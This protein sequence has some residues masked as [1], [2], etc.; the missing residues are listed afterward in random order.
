MRTQ[1]IQVL[2]QLGS[3]T[4]WV[5]CLCPS[6]DLAQKCTTDLA[7]VLPP[8]AVLGGR[9]ARIGPHRVSVTH[10]GS[11][12]FVPLKQDFKVTLI[13]GDHPRNE[14]E[15]W[16]ARSSGLMLTSLNQMPDRSGR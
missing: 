15:T 10:T 8:G 5:V 12:V 11:S 4:P 16:I 1:I 9:T 13:G 3:E 14:V 6:E 7:A 2:E